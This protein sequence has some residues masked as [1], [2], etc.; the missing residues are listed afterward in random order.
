MFFLN[1]FSNISIICILTGTFGGKTNLS[2]IF[3]TSESI[4]LKEQETGILE[5]FE[6]LL[7][8]LDDLDL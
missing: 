6:L 4:D 7:F 8:E 1:K 3:I 2:C 5:G